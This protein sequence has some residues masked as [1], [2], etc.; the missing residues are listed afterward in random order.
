ML[1]D[2]GA[3][4]QPMA[5][6]YFFLYS[7]SFSENWNCAVRGW[8]EGDRGRRE[9]V[10]VIFTGHFLEGI[11]GIFPCYINSFCIFTST[12]SHCFLFLCLFKFTS[13]QTGQVYF[14][15]PNLKTN[16]PSKFILFEVYRKALCGDPY[17][18]KGLLLSDEEIAGT[19]RFFIRKKVE[20]DKPMFLYR[21]DEI[22]MVKTACGTVL[23][24]TLLDKSVASLDHFFEQNSKWRLIIRIVPSQSI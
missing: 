12:F 24:S 17:I 6:L 2:S 5:P 7:C 21:D 13:F 4:Q 10:A 15:S 9:G 18:K 22:T 11:V 19:I 23:N 16:M 8:G 14:L 3:T 1:F 20:N